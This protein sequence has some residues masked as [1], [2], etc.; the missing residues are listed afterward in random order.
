MAQDGLDV[1]TVSDMCTDLVVSG[2]VHPEFHQVEKIVGDYSLELGGSANI[3]AC[4]MA[5]LGA[6]VG[7]IGYVGQ[8][9]FG[10]FALGALQQ[11]GVDTTRVKRHPSTKTGIGIAL[12]EGGDRAILTY[13][14]TIDAT[15]E[16]DLDETLLH[17]CTHWHIA[18]YFLLR[19]LRR[20][21]PH[22]LQKCRRAGVTTSLDPNWDPDNLWDGVLDVLPYVDVFLP[23]D[24]EA[25]SLTGEKDIWK[26]AKVLA[27]KGPLTVVKCGENGAIAVQGDRTWQ[28]NGADGQDSPLC[29]VDSIGAG[30]NFDAGLIRAWLLGHDI[31][32]S[33]QLAHLCALSSLRCQGGIQGQLRQQ[34]GQKTVDTTQ[35]P[36]DDKAI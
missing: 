2:N 33:L 20:F 15:L 34:V 29:L 19:N 5:K 18:S 24:R 31:D 26:A 4:Q 1:L 13:P 9:V 25:L 3:F 7:I 28:I 27:G 8:D 14:G 22:W 16:E 12:A 10:E 32:Y 35:G 36:R 17:A 21:W 23:N 30:D 6:R 11:I